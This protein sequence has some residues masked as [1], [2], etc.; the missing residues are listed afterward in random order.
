M[1]G[2]ELEGATYTCPIRQD[3][4]G[5]VIYGDHVT[6][7]SGTGAVHTAPGHGMDDYLVAQKFGVP[8][9]MPVDD[10]GVLTEAAG[11]FAG[12]DIDEA[13]PQI[14]EW[15]REEGTLV[16]EKKISHSYPHCWRCH[17]PVI[18]RAT[19]Q[20]FVSMDEDRPARAR[21]RHHPQRGELGARVGPESHRLHGGRPPRL[22]ASRASAAGACRC[23]CSN[24]R[25]AARPWRRRRPSTP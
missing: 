12:L 20:W 16:A 9:L 19:D 22:G 15:L 18:F 14:I 21:A 4:K 8:T 23:R 25:S 10:N 1:K 7:D 6:L 13:N 11:R 17:Q 5:R 3:L 24:A 2:K